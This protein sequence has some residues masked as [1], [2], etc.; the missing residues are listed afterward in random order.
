MKTN[1]HTQVEPGGFTRLDLLAAAAVAALL[2][3]AALPALGGAARGSEQAVCLNNL[4]HIGRA[5]AEWGTGRPHP[6]PWWVAPAQGGSYLGGGMLPAANNAWFQFAWISNELASPRVLVCPADPARHPARDFSSAPDGGFLNAAQRDNSVSYAL[7]VDTQE[8]R[9]NTV[10]A[11]DR[12]LRADGLGACASGLNPVASMYAP[13][14]AAA[15][16][17]EVHM[18]SGNLLYYDGSVERVPQSRLADRLSFRRDMGGSQWLI[19]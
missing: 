12:D 13:L 11:G 9:P 8:A 4:R 5:F 14:T 19:P 16:T 15:W 2:V 17:N 1:T 3:A 10:V 18:G 7:Q 6:S